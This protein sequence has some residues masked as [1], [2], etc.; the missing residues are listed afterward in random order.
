MLRVEGVTF[1]YAGM[2]E[3]FRFDLQVDPGTVLAV[4]GE[5]G[6]GKSTLL[7]LI[8]GFQ[9]VGTG[10]IAWNDQEFQDLPPEQRPVTILFQNHNLFE[11]LSVE[12]N[13][14]IGIERSGRIGQET[15]DRVRTALVE[16]GLAGLEKRIAATLS[17]G[18][19]QR[20][21]LA[22]ALLRKQPIMLL[23]EPCTGLDEQT[24]SEILAL[25]KAIAV[26]QNRAVIVATHD[27]EDARV[28][29]ADIL[30]IGP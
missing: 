5:S 2:G 22:R 25:I 21:A 28:L 26:K 20:V 13:V 30:K 17:G 24:R 3:P 18:Q 4:M 6:S 11:H 23:D 29:G 15:R 9:R 14:S 1:Q 10:I 16:V 12:Q 8:A 27:R 19:Q 7:D